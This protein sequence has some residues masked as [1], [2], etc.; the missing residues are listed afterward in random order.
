MIE[1]RNLYKQYRTTVAVAGLSF[2]VPPGVCAAFLGPNGAGKSSTL[3]ILSTLLQPTAGTVKIAGFDVSREAPRVRQCL[4]YLPETPPLYGEMTVTEL[5]H[6]VAE[7]RGVH[8]A[9]RATRIS[10]I[11]GQFGLV[12]VR[13]QLCGELSRGF[14][15][16]VG[17]A[18]ALVHQ[19]QVVILDEP[20]NGLDPGQVIEFRKLIKTLVPQC[21][22]LLSTHSLSEV[23][24]LCSQVIILS[25]GRKVL[26][27]AW[28]DGAD[29]AELE[30]VYWQSVNTEGVEVHGTR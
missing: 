12:E 14:R 13:H 6:F 4:G 2:S 22:V 21:T 16:R 18:Q 30:R 5:L 20:T 24:A 26:E 29:V 28:N 25:Q 9:A 1:V 17:L 3:R 27:R 23:T 11:L 19:P 8:Q 7:L 15:Q 10:E